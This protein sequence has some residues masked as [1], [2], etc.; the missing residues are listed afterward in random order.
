MRLSI[1][2]NTRG[3]TQEV[4]SIDTKRKRQEIE[5]IADAEAE[6]KIGPRFKLWLNTLRDVSID[7]KRYL[8]EEERLA[9][10][11]KERDV[12][13]STSSGCMYRAEWHVSLEEIEQNYSVSIKYVRQEKTIPKVNCSI[14][15][16]WVEYA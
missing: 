6:A 16:G 7:V 14:P 9:S 13:S 5:A 11:R 12:W 2:F 3:E 15:G 10:S 4:E 1:G 8:C